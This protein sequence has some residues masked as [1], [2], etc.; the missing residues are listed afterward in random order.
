[1]VVRCGCVLWAVD[2]SLWLCACDCVFV[3]VLVVMCLRLCVVAVCCDCELW[4]CD[5]ALWLCVVD[6]S[7]WIKQTCTPGSTIS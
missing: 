4:L 6:V 3:A 7:L 2:M 1:M 5:C